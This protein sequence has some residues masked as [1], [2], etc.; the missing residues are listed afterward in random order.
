MKNIP[1]NTR[2]EIEEY[3]KKSNL[4]M[5]LRSYSYVVLIFIYKNSLKLT[6]CES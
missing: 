3:F 6:A 1:F 5:E 4:K 2:L